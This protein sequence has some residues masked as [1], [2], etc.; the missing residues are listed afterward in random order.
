MT[1]IAITDEH[2]RTA[3]T[4][5]LYDA[6]CDA[7]DGLWERLNEAASNTID[8]I[9]GFEDDGEEWLAVGDTDARVDVLVGI[10]QDQILV[11]AAELG[12]AVELATI[13]ERI[14]SGL[15]MCVERIEDDASVLKLSRDERE[16]LIAI[17]DAAAALS[18]E[19]A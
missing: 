8:G 7:T 2:V 15:K 11:A 4:A 14:A 10:R 17:R 9:A 1:T 13:R 16:R 19:V 6:A 5:A 12:S 18:P 3:L